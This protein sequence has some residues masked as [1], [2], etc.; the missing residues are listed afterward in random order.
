MSCPPD[1]PVAEECAEQCAHACHRPT[2]AYRPTVLGRPLTPTPIGAT[3][4]SFRWS[5]V[6]RFEEITVPGATVC[7][8][9][10]VPVER[11]GFDAESRA[12][13]EQRVNE[14][15]LDRAAKFPEPPRPQMTPKIW[16]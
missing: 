5:A 10:G 7:G 4:H 3:C 1:C 6:V 9:C 2:L 14:D 16:P 13:G 12:R 8:N 15:W 11:C